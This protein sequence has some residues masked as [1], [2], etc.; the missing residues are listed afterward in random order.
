MRTPPSENQAEPYTCMVQVMGTNHFGATAVFQGG[1]SCLW[2]TDQSY[3]FCRNGSHWRNPGGLCALPTPLWGNCCRL[4]GTSRDWSDSA[5]P[6]VPGPWSLSLVPG[7]WPLVPVPGPGPW[8]LAPGPWPLVPGPWPLV[9]G[10][11]PC[12]LYTSPSPRDGLLSRMP[13][14]A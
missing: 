5:W 10:P 6:L 12:L 11:W 14:S 13:S 3:T 9:P 8:S 4:L 1:P 7:P 2:K